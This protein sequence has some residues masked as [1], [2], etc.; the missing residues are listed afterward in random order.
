[1]ALRRQ[2]KAPIFLLPQSDAGIMP[3]YVG[4]FVENVRK[5]SPER[6]IQSLCEK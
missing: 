5:E 4:C 6:G 2:N 3:Q 1:M